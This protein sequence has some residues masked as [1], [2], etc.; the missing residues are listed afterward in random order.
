MRLNLIDEIK[1][2]QESDPMMKELKE[3][4]QAGQEQRFQVYQGVLKLNGRLC[5][6]NVL[7]L[8]QKILHEAHYAPY[9]VHSGATKMYH[10]IKATYWWSGL[11][12]DVAKIYCFMSYLSASETRTPKADRIITR[13]TNTRMEMGSN[14]HGFCCRATS[15]PKGV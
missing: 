13:T 8:K 12:K 6:P 1:T 15:D 4:V 9:N 10:D 3:K 14:H 7:E 11:K 2:T 5:V